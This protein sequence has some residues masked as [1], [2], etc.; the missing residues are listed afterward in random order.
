[1]NQSL[2]ISNHIPVN[3][4]R[5]KIWWKRGADRSRAW[6]EVD[7]RQSIIAFPRFP[8]EL[9]GSNTGT[10]QTHTARI[11]ADTHRG[12]KK[13]EERQRHR[14]ERC[15]RRSGS[16]RFDWSKR[17]R[18]HQFCLS[19]SLYVSVRIKW[20]RR[21]G[22]GGLQHS[23]VILLLLPPRTVAPGKVL[24]LLSPSFSSNL[25][26]ITSWFLSTFFFHILFLFFPFDFL[27][28]LV[29]SCFNTK[30]EL[31]LVLILFFCILSAHQSSL[32]PW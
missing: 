20:G 16:W 13:I 2:P 18:F 30:A 31:C 27:P 28:L 25:F 14:H 23:G 6:L 7:S 11:H 5:K 24:L 15:C 1:M 21:R 8:D 3:L 19:L 26:C 32:S 12:E 17:R 22:G 4:K 9:T 29:W 10:T